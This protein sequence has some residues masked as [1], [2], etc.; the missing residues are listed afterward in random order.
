MSLL[1][2]F[3]GDEFVPGEVVVS[4]IDVFPSMLLDVSSDGA[5]SMLLDTMASL[6]AKVEGKPSV[7]GDASAEPS[8]QVKVDA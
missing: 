3:N 2:L 7:D 8:I 4:Q 1:L 6:D 5:I